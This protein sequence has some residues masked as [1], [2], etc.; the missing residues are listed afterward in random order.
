MPV[1]AKVIGKTVKYQA[2]GVTLKGYLAY[3]SAI[4]GKRPGILVVHE[5]WGLNDYVRRRARMLAKLG[6]VALAVD[7]Y[8]NGKQATN[9]TDAGKLSSD[10][11]KNFNVTKERFAA[12]ENYLKE[13]SIADTNRLAAIG[14]CFGGGVV[15]NIAREG[16]DLKGIVSF[17]G[18][19]T[20]V[21]HAEPGTIKAKLLVMQGSEDKFATPDQIEAFKKEMTEAGADYTFIVY[22]GAMH[23]FSNPAATELG[24]KFKIPIA[25]NAKADKASWAEMKKFMKETL[26]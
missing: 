6:Y 11:M 24:K 8:G 7:I 19:L 2:G 18:N 15:L 9:P 17:H 21:K 20:A 14:Y 1:H 25:Y 12:A 13:Q 3:D 16:T 22:P 4:K 10:A 5:W 26:K 23:A